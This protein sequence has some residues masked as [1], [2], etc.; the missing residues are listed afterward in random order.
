MKE[1][2]NEELG[3]FELEEELNPNYKSPRGLRRYANLIE[4]VID[5][6]EE[7]IN[8]MLKEVK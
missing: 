7:E 3:F 8:E 6:S 4:D 5:V 1:V 2:N